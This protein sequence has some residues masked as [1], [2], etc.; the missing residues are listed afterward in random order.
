M[1]FW[2]V[3][4]F[5]H[6]DCHSF[7]LDMEKTKLF[8]LLGH[9]HLPASPTMV[10]LKDGTLSSLGHREVCCQSWSQ[11][12]QGVAKVLISGNTWQLC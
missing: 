3:F 12:L 4:A 10:D 1:W 11:G 7:L 6:G 9:F 2:Q 5:P 8:F